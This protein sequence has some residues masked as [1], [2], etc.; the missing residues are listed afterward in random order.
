V[1]NNWYFFIKK[2]WQNKTKTTILDEQ[3][4]H[5]HPKGNDE[6][7]EGKK[8]KTL[9]FRGLTR[10]NNG[11]WL[12]DFT[13]FCSFTSCLTVELYVI[14]HNL[15]IMYDGGTWTLFLNQVLG[16][17]IMSDVQPHHPHVPL[18]SKSVQLQH[19]DWN[20]NFHHTLH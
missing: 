12:L 2:K 19:Q 11:D 20:V 9:G 1:T 6:V 3:L 14:F 18:I 16:W 15:R 10:N 7:D 13:G 5:H 17:L 4:L 8:S